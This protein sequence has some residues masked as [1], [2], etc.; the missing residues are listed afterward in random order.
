MSSNF[1]KEVYYESDDNTISYN[2]NECD[3]S[4]SSSSDEEKNELKGGVY[5]GKKFDPKIAERNKLK[6]FDSKGKDDNKNKDI[7][8]TKTERKKPPHLNKKEFDIEPDVDKANIHAPKWVRPEDMTYYDVKKI[9]NKS[10]D[11]RIIEL[12]SKKVVNEVQK[13]NVKY[14]YNIH[15][16]APNGNH[17]KA[18]QVYMDIDPQNI[19]DVDKLYFYSNKTREEFMR[20]C[21]WKFVKNFNGEYIE[22]K[23]GNFN[24]F[25]NHIKFLYINPLHDKSQGLNPYMTIHNGMLIYKSQFPILPDNKQGKSK[26]YK[27]PRNI[28]IRIY[29]MSFS[30]FFEVSYS[31]HNSKKSS[32]NM[33][34]LKYDINKELVLYRKFNKI[35]TNKES[36]NF[37]MMAAY[38]VTANQYIKSR[39]LQ[40]ENLK[41]LGNKDFKLDE[42]YKKELDNLEKLYS[43]DINSI[44]FIPSTQTMLTYYQEYISDENNDKNDY[45][46]FKKFIVEKMKKSE[47]FDYLSK[48]EMYRLLDERNSIGRTLITVTENN[49]VPLGEFNSDLYKSYEGQE[50]LQQVTSGYRTKDEFKNILFQL[51]VICILLEKHNINIKNLNIFD[52]F[53]VKTVKIP[54]NQRQYLNFKINGINYYLPHYGFIIKLNLNFSHFRSSI[55]PKDRM[56]QY[57]TGYIRNIYDLENKTLPWIDLY[58]SLLNQINETSFGK[59]EKIYGSK[60]KDLQNIDDEKEILKYFNSYFDP[61]H[62]DKVDLSLFTPGPGGDFVKHPNVKMGDLVIKRI[63]FNKYKF[64]V[65]INGNKSNIYRLKDDTLKPEYELPYDGF[66]GKP[67]IV[68]SYKIK[69]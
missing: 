39:Q 13:D 10:M 1:Y 54:K 18:N 29:D 53:Y 45:E 61:L 35:V 38:F 44:N 40:I 12:L 28:D 65:Y 3:S 58:Q 27:E 43:E 19:Y 56:K 30:E 20:F 5:L 26:N 67:M 2:K 15:H 63:G 57:D 11:D 6:K 31:S 17:E 36:P 69:V 62:D 47:K 16:P 7:V 59:F 23:E 21:R 50:K 60:L 55:K 49:D 41:A 33:K 14:Y 37:T 52:H 25:I 4:S 66:I 42:T 32:F 48:S 51:M 34:N 22:P 64:H 68:D 9:A 8:P 46:K 24:N